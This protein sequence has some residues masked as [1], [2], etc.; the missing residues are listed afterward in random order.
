MEMD[1]VVWL[2][3]LVVFLGIEVVT[4]GLTTIW[5]AGGSIAGLAVSLLGGSILLQAVLFCIVTVLLL[6]F[7]RPFAVKYINRNRTKTNVNSVIG[8]T[9]V[10]TAPINN[11]AGEGQ[12]KVDGQIWTARAEDDSDLIPAGTKVKVIRVSGVKL[13]V[14]ELEE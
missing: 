13:I 2:G 3:L 5:F 4:L 14:K 10:V 11:L 12:A 6:I 7:T 9:A 1:S 8:R